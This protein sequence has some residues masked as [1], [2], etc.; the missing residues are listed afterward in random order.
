MSLRNSPLINS[1]LTIYVRYQSENTSTGLVLELYA[2]SKEK[3]SDLYDL[4]HRTVMEYVIVT[5]P[6]FA[7]S[8]FQN[9][10]SSNF[11][12]LDP[13]AFD[14]TSDDPDKKKVIAGP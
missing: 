6:L 10:S 9:P 3:T 5:A 7:V 13:T 11:I 2:F 12:R 8:I 4:T 14:A 1:T